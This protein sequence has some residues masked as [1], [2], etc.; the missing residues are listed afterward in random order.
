HT[1]DYADQRYYNS[2][3][4]RFTTPDP[5]KASAGA[6]GPQSWNRYSYVEGDPVNSND[7]SGLAKEA[8]GEGCKWDSATSTLTCYVVG[9]SVVVNGTFDAAWAEKKGLARS[10]GWNAYSIGLRRE[11][12]EMITASGMTAQNRAEIL[13]ENVKAGTVTDCEALVM[14]AQGAAN[15]TTASGYSPQSDF[16]FVGQFGIF[17]PSSH[18]VVS[19]INEA[20]SALL[21]IASSPTPVDF[22]PK[23]NQSGFASQ[24][25]DPGYVEQTHHFSAFF[26]FGFYMGETLGTIAAIAYDFRNPADIALGRAAASIG[27]KLRSG[28]ISVFGVAGEI[29]KLCR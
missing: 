21:P 3:W 9:Y 12:L 4:G 13:A 11:L 16:S 28:D 5:Y 27:S 26:Q 22:L 20:P 1:L 7:P 23:S 14:F 17:V 19:G 15:I 6:E 25:Q 10:N 29:R 24:Y 2:F 8:A 18:S